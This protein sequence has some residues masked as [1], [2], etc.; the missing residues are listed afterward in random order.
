MA[1]RIAIIAVVWTLFVATTAMAQTTIASYTPTAAP[2][3]VVWLGAGIQRT[4]SFTH[5]G[6]AIGNVTFRTGNH[7]SMFPAYPV[8]ISLRSTATG[9]D[10]A[11][12]T[13][14]TLNANA[15]HTAPLNVTLSAGTYFIVW[16]PNAGSSTS[17]YGLMAFESATYS[18]GTAGYIQ[19]GAYVNN[20]GRDNWFAV[21]GETATATPTASPTPTPSPSPTPTIAPTST[22]NT[23]PVPFC[24][25]FDF[26]VSNGGWSSLDGLGNYVTGTGWGS[27][28]TTYPDY[29]GIEIDMA[30]YATITDFAVTI[31]TPLLTA[32]GLGRIYGGLGVTYWDVFAWRGDP[33]PS[34]TWSLSGLDEYANY[35]QLATDSQEGTVIAYSGHIT[36]VEVRGEY[37]NVHPFG[38]DTCTAITPTPSPTATATPSPTIDPEFQFAWCHDFHFD[39]IPL[40]TSPQVGYAYSDYGNVFGSGFESVDSVL[41]YAYLHPEDV[42]LGKVILTLNPVKN[43]DL[44]VQQIIGN[45]N[46]FGLQLSVN[47]YIKSNEFYTFDTEE[48]TNWDS[49]WSIGVEDIDLTQSGNQLSF[50]LMTDTGAQLRVSS[51]RLYGSANYP[52]DPNPFSP[53][54]DTDNCGRD[55]LPT[56][57]L[58]PTPTID[59]Y[60]TPSATPTLLPTYTPTPSPFATRQPTITPTYRPT[61]TPAPTMNPTEVIEWREDRDDDTYWWQFGGGVN[62]WGALRAIFDGAR[63]LISGTITNVGRLTSI[64]SGIANQWEDTPPTVIPSTPRCETNPGA[65]QICAIFYLLEHTLFSGTAGR[66]ILFALLAAVDIAI[67][68]RVYGYYKTS[69][70][71]IKSVTS[72]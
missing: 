32:G 39:E 4:Q 33:P 37:V 43:G 11:S 38:A 50:L 54:T 10:L 22:P 21:Y 8:T 56:P 7:V 52:N 14:S 57:V 63:W 58:S 3:S 55:P 53:I 20:I 30:N 59:P 69:V 35:I 34:L 13:F 72:S 26:S 31:D 41:S 70:E 67:I 68:L 47:Q 51:L 27:G 45:V 24:N 62:W 71:M 40:S 19:S 9:A 61:I 65:S 28:S 5:T 2:G 42:R 25:V 64:A 18:G 12:Y 1:K 23:P 60:L 6:G 49:W 66:A 44:S 29:I 15:L 17:Q 48:T 36:R 46:I 16:T